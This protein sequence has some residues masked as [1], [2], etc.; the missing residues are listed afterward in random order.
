MVRHHKHPDRVD[1]NYHYILPDDIQ[2][3]AL[4][5]SQA[6]ALVLVL[7]QSLGLALVLVLSQSLGLALVL[8]RCWC[9]C[10]RDSLFHLSP[11]LFRGEDDAGPR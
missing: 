9:G 10:G 4:A 7:S 11:D 8:L 5:L 3:P 6:L 2:N 1:A